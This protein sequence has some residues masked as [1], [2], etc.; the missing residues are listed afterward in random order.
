MKSISPR[1]VAI[2]SIALLLSLWYVSARIIHSDMLPSPVGVLAVIYE[3]GRSGELFYHTGITLWRVAASFIISMLAGMAIG[4]LMGYFKTVDTLFDPWLIF[5]LNIPALVVMIL[6]YIWLGLTEIAVIAA[7][8]INKIPNVVVTIREG[9][10]AMDRGLQQMAQV[11]HFSRWKT[12]NHIVIPELS[13]YIAATTRS[14]IA[15]IWKIVL[16]AELLGRSN[17]VGFQLHLQFQLFNITHIIAWGLVF[18]IIMQ[19]VE[20][21]FLRPFEAYANRWRK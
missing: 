7:V 14:G 21:L 6:T 15:L 10:R 19:L 8:A 16:V 1:V 4:F 5:F 18:V 3:I 11:F 20:L 12:L 17:G 9:V 13:P 2:A